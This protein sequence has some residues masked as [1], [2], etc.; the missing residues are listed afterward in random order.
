[1]AAGICTMVF[2]GSARTRATKS[3]GSE[4]LRDEAPPH[5]FDLNRPRSWAGRLAKVDE[6]R[7][8]EPTCGLRKCSSA[9]AFHQA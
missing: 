2:D 6:P 1:M 5:L 9:S 8:E 7:R 3:G 4:P